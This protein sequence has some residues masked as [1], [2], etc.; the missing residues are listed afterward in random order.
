MNIFKDYEMIP[1]AGDS[2]EDIA[3]MEGFNN[4]LELC[5]ELTNGDKENMDISRTTIRD[6]TTGSDRYCIRCCIKIGYTS[7]WINGRGPYCGDCVKLVDESKRCPHCDGFGYMD[8][9][10]DK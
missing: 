1:H 8:E 2:L 3:Y 4:A 10:G 5:E 6:I 9:K 7:F